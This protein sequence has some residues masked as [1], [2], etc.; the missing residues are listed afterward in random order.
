M[1]FKSSNTIP[2]WYNTSRI[3][4]RWSMLRKSVAL[5]DA[6]FK[7]FFHVISSLRMTAAI[8]CCLDWKT[9]ISSFSKVNICIILQEFSSAFWIKQV[10][11]FNTICNKILW[12]LL[13]SKNFQPVYPLKSYQSVHFGKCLVHWSLNWYILY[14]TN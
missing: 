1:F 9:I 11:F 12:I 7:N 14:K 10:P 8:S 5:D 4:P 3:I 6:Q 2:F 13:I